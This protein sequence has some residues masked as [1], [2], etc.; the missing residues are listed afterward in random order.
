MRGGYLLDTSVLTECLFGRPRA[1]DLIAPWLWET[2]VSTS[3]WSYAETLEYLYGRPD[4]ARHMAALNRM[5]SIIDV[6]MP[7]IEIFQAY[8]RLRRRLR[9]PF[10]PGLIG[11]FDTLIAATAMHHDL[12]LVTTD[13]DF[14]RVPDVRIHLLPPGALRRS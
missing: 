14:T 8:G 2:S 6:L 1:M 12:T 3:T 7:E 9:P 5:T 11:D 13:G 4:E 10:G